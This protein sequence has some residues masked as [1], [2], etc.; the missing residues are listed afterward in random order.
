MELRYLKKLKSGSDV[1][2]IA[3]ELGSPITL[4]NEAVYDITRA[5]CAWYEA[6]YFKKPAAIAVG[7]DVRISTERILERV[8]A[9]INDAG[10][11]VLDCGLCSTPSMFMLLKSGRACAASIMITASH[12]PSDRNGL[13]F[14]S[15]SGGLESGDID[16]ILELAAAADFERSAVRGKVTKCDYMPEY[17]ADLVKKVRT[18]CGED[19]P[20]EGMKIIVDA[21]NGAGGFFCEGVLQ[22]LGADTQGSIYTEPDGTFPNHIP[23]PEDKKAIDCLKAAVLREKAD[24]GIIFDTDVDRAGAVD[25]D[26]REINRND[27]IALAAAM[28]LENRP[29]TIVTDSVTSDGLTKFIESLGGKH[30]RFKRGYKN[31]IDE[32]MRRNA[33]GE[34][35]PLAIETSGHAAFAENYFLDDGAYL[36]VRI[37]I[38]LAQQ[39]KKGQTLSRLIAGLE[40]PAEEDE[41]RISFNSLTEDFRADG[42]K[43]IEHIKSAAPGMGCSLAHDNYEGVK[44]NFDK[45]NGDGWFLVRLS[46]HDPVMPINFESRCAGGNRIIAAKLLQLLQ[47]CDFLD[48]TNLEKFIQNDGQ[49]NK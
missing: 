32:A 4:T 45:N 18:A 22:P 21:G 19:R 15:E 12:L 24:L 42:A 34:Y 6:K 3:S 29:G 44:V 17:C 10:I 36:V 7:H 28:V 27:L 14:F 49:P 8:T 1:R 40:H 41:V 43:V 5:F 20:L 13:K 33:N 9:A 11:D 16:D 26:G 37:L 30:L 31:V 35:C 38:C 48:V 25:C 23:N 2:G 47:G 39:T 46:V